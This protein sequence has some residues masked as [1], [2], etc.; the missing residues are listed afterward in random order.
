VGL[1]MLSRRGTPGWARRGPVVSRGREG[2][3]R[4]TGEPADT[5]A[6]VRAGGLAATLELLSGHRELI[7]IGTEGVRWVTVLAGHA[8]HHLIVVDHFPS[9]M[10]SSEMIGGRPLLEA[11][12]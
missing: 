4:I 1:G 8:T 10:L 2:S 11:G 12:G 6:Q 9:T 7:R 5:C 3:V